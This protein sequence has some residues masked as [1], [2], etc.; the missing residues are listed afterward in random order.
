MRRLAV[1]QMPV[2]QLADDDSPIHE[3]ARDQNQCKQHDN[4]E[5]KSKHPHQQN[6]G[7]ERSWNGQPYQQRHPP[8]HHGHHHDEYQHNGG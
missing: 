4:I 5:R 2:G 8:A 1:V 3:H 6:A 7:E